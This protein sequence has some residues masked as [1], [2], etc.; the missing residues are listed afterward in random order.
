M[1]LVVLL[2]DRRLGEGRPRGLLAATFVGL[3][4]NMRFGAEFFK[5][6]LVFGGLAPDETE[7]VIRTIP[8]PGL[9]MGQLLSLP[10]IALGIYG[11]VRALRRR[12]PAAVLSRYDEEPAGE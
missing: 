2:I 6:R 1:A 4:F 9:T 11:V 10:F 7:L 5:E 3:Y 8:N 12:D